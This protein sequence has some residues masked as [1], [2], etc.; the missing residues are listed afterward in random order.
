MENSRNRLPVRTR[1]LREGKIEQPMPSVAVLVKNAVAA[2]ARVGMALVRREK[3][4]RSAEE[5]AVFLA[6]CKGCE[7]WNKAQGRCG[8]C[9]CVGAWKSWLATERC[10]KG[11]WDAALTSTG[12]S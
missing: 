9:G 1:V 10:P 3:I 12:E 6:I 7:F 5:Q 4:R 8:V 2:G 11:K